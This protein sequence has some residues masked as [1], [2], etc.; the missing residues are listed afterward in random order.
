MA[1]GIKHN[2]ERKAVEVA[3]TGALNHIDKKREAGM[4]DFIN[5]MEKTLGDTWPPRAYEALRQVYE[6][7]DSKWCKFT[8]DLFDN[9]DH[10]I[11]KSLALNMGYG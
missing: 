8:N 9:V 7:P 2:I 5:L 3:I 10:G 11:I 1:D 6:N 4:I